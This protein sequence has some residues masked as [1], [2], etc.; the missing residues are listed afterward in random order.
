MI[1]LHY[2]NILY[3][4]KPLIY[5][6]SPSGTAHLFNAGAR[7]RKSHDKEEPMLPEKTLSW[8]VSRNCM[9]ELS[10]GNRR[11][12][13]IMSTTLHLATR[14][15]FRRRSSTSPSST[16]SA[17]KV[18]LYTPIRQQPASLHFAQRSR[19]TST[20]ALISVSGRIFS[21][22]LPVRQQR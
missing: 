1:V 19:T 2:Y 21:I 20:R 14:A 17:R 8:G 7:Q 12:E 13:R 9:R 5:T 6:G 10:A 11:S 15:S 22:S 3:R 4:I 18:I 16:S